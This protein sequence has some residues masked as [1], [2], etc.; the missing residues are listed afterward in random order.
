[1]DIL[2]T[3]EARK[4]WDKQEKLWDQEKVA[5]KKLMEDVISTLGKQTQEKLKSNTSSGSNI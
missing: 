3:E 4:M 5:R 2:F 1:M